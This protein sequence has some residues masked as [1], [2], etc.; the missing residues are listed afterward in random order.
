MAVDEVQVQA[1]FL[2]C[3]ENPDDFTG[4]C[5]N[6]ITE[7]FAREPSRCNV[8]ILM[9]HTISISF[10]CWHSHYQLASYENARLV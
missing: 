6:F 8:C 5:P 10:I 7:C 1:G 9:F 4:I 2:A 3:A